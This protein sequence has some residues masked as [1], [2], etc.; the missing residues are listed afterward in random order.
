[1]LIWTP[2][3]DDLL[4]LERHAADLLQNPTTFCSAATYFQHQNNAISLSFTCEKDMYSVTPITFF[5][6]PLA[7]PSTPST[8][9][10]ETKTI[11][12]K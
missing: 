5:T 3:T 12:E 10:R 9:S 8:Q 7:Q 4:Q 1:M 6:F 2:K 11:K